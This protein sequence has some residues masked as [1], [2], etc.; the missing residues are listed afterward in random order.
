MSTRTYGQYCPLARSLDLVGERW[1]LLVVRELMAGPKRYSDL[2]A[3]LPG[4]GTSLLATRLKS[5]ETQGVID[6]RFLPPP[7]ASSVY[8]LTAVGEE[9]VNALLPLVAWGAR[10]ALGDFEPDQTYH[11]TWPLLII[12][13][14]VEPDAAWSDTYEFRIDSSV[15]HLRTVDGR[16]TVH[17][18]PAERPDV[19]LTSDIGTFVGL[20]TGAVEPA[21]ALSAGQLQLT[22]D[23]D[24]LGR[25][26]A[27][28][29]QVAGKMAVS[30]P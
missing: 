25:F 30:A 23:P 19:V 17:D 5:L 3:A 14:M 16:L 2:L 21:A 18:G 20:G 26:T 27:L 9:L 29:Q 15:A 6:R 11:A 28:M 10:H 12:K 24:A 8:Q 7:A 4:I 1:T 13:A 22:G